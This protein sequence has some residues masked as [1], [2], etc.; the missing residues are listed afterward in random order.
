MAE[1]KEE[2]Q[3]KELEDLCAVKAQTPGADEKRARCPTIDQTKMI[4]G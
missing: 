4:R 2:A 3:R 1:Y